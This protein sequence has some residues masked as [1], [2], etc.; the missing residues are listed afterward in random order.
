MADRTGI[1][2]VAVMGDVV[3]DLRDAEVRGNVVDIAATAVMGDVKI[4][5][6]DGVDVDLEG[7]AIMGDKKVRVIEAP[8]ARTCRSCGSRRSPSWATSR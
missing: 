3:L 4:I 8:R 2:A 7:V 5:V 1:G 6:P